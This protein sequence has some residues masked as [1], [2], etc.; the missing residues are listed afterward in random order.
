MGSPPRIIRKCRVAGGSYCRK[1]TLLWV[2]RSRF[3]NFARRAE[4]VGVPEGKGDPTRQLALGGLECRNGSTA[5]TGENGTWATDKVVVLNVCRF[6][7]EE[8]FYKGVDAYAGVCKELY[9]AHP[10]LRQRVVFVLCGKATEEDVSAVGA[11]GVRVFANVDDAELINLYIAA[12][13]YLNL[14]RWEGYNLGIGQA[15][16]LGLPVIASDIQAHREFPIVT[17]DD[18]VEMVS[19][20]R[21]I[22]DDLVGGAAGAT[23]RPTVY[24][25]EEPLTQLALEITELCRQHPG[26][27]LSD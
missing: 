12:D 8:R 23:R 21:R 25:W 24:T 17:S 22:A 7:R 11:L 26:E 10:D 1:A 15:L 9:S 4:G 20:L 19:R 16:A 2:L 27:L 14:S 3:R 5:G 13:I 6:H 18:P